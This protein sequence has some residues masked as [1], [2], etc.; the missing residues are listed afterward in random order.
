MPDYP[1]FSLPTIPAQELDVA[2]AIGSFWSSYQTLTIAGNSTEDIDIEPPDDGYYYKIQ[3]IMITNDGDYPLSAILTLDGISFMGLLGQPSLLFPV[4]T[5]PLIVVGYGDKFTISVTNRD[6]SAHDME[7]VILAT[8]MY[9]PGGFTRVPIA[10]F[11]ASPTSGNFP[12]T[13]SFTDQSYRFPTSWWWDF[14]DGTPGSD[15]QHPT[16]EYASGGI[17]DVRLYATNGVGTDTLLRA[18]YIA[19]TSLQDLTTYTEYDPNSRLTVAGTKCTLSGGYRNQAWN[20]YKD[21]GDNYFD[22][23]HIDFEMQLTSCAT[24]GLMSVVGISNSTGD[25]A[26][27]A[28]TDYL[29]FMLRTGTSDYRITLLSGDGT[30]TDYMAAAEDVTYYCTL[31]RAPGSDAVYLDV[32][33]DSA[34]TTLLDTLVITGIGTTK[35][36]YIHAMVSRYSDSTASASGWVDNIN[37]A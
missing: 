14:G 33:S 23:I 5:N 35:H 1:D 27:W 7:V 13:V 15:L 31:R 36:R 37:L 28:A 34:R 20:L 2:P 24:W 26:S 17:Y 4:H 18:D 32:Y 11:S 16:H 25:S 19:V 30:S 29:V 8:K 3:L 9:M 21:F 10:A 22:G 6:S 12:L